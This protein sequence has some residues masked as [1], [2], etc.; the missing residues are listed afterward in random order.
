M[1]MRKFLLHVKNG[2]FMIAMFVA[3]AGGLSL[4]SCSG[5]TPGNEDNG[6]LTDGTGGGGG[7]EG[8]DTQEPP[9]YSP[10]IFVGVWI[11]YQDSDNQGNVTIYDDPDMEYSMMFESDKKHGSY[12]IFWSGTPIIEDFKWSM[13][14]GKKM[15]IV[16]LSG[17]EYDW[18]VFMEP[19]NTCMTLSKYT[20]DYYEAHIY[21]KK[22]Y[23]P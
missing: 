6:E 1:R 22:G 5:D 18:D 17:G 16:E 10:D 14:P 3:L 2:F 4:A 8:G 13:G 9:Y 11:L 15:H 19:G 12:R 23:L 21:Y 20:G 7:D